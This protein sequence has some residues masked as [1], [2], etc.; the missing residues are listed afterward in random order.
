MSMSVPSSR[1]VRLSRARVF[2]VW[3]IPVDKMEVGWIAVTFSILVFFAY[4]TPLSGDI[5]F[6]DVYLIRK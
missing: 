4:L 1:A 3:N 5:L 2:G 6:Q